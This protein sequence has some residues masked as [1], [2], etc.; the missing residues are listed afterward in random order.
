MA[1]QS[2]LESF[3]PAAESIEDYKERFDFHCTAHQIPEGRRKALFLTQ[4]GRDAF[5]KLKTLVSPTPLNDLSLSAIV[6]TMTQHYKKDTV[7]IAE[8]FKFFKRVQQEKESVADYVAE[9][10]RLSKTCNFGDYLETALRD[11][12]VCG[13]CELTME[14]ELLCIKDFTLSMAIDKARAAETVNREVKNLPTDAEA[15][16]ISTQQY[17]CPRCGHQGHTKN[18]LLL[19]QQALPNLQ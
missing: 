19:P 14:K 2:S 3:N 7:E 8:R 1:T 5:A 6:T 9:L 10:R 11:Q 4:I 12:V 17:P 13:L 15:L 18:H 16:K